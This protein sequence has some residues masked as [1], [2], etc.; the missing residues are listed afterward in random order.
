MI[1]KLADSPLGAIVTHAVIT[2]NGK[3]VATAES[4]A[5]LLWRAVPDDDS[6]DTPSVVIFKEEQEAVK[7]LFFIDKDEI[8]IA[9]SKMMGGVGGAEMKAFVKG[10]KV[11]MEPEIEE[12]LLYEFEYPIKNVRNL[13]ATSDGSLLVGPGFE[14]LKDHL[15]IFASKAGVLVHKIVLKYANFKDYTSLLPVPK[16]ATQVILIYCLSLISYRS[17]WTLLKFNF[18]K[19]IPDRSYRFGQRKHNRC[20]DKTLHSKCE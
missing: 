13:I 12:R 4:G 17:H 10:R 15:Y 14:K 7:Q 20:K 1:D 9:V 18:V 11:V 6:P 16:R 5:I 8:L 2:K 19:Y 3:Y